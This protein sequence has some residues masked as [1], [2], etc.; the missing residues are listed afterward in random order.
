MFI[1]YNQKTIE[2]HNDEGELFP[3]PRK[4][5]EESDGK[6]DD[7]D[8][9]NGFPELKLIKLD[10]NYSREDTWNGTEYMRTEPNSAYFRR[11]RSL[12]EETP[13]N[14]TWAN[15]QR[16]FSNP[17]QLVKAPS[18]GNEELRYNH[19]QNIMKSEMMHTN[20]FV[21]EKVKV[22]N[23]YFPWNNVDKILKNM[24]QFG[25]NKRTRRR[26]VLRN[27]FY[28]NPLSL[29][30]S[31]LK[32]REKEVLYPSTGK[33]STAGKRKGIERLKSYIEREGTIIYGQ[34]RKGDLRQA[35]MKLVKMMT[36][37]H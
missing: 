22:M 32:L 29:I 4:S 9:G 25:R 1:C 15:N 7:E 19:E 2:E 17:P 18:N 37:N 30:G 27:V 8:G 21:Y 31:Y 35:Q 13:S 12:F 26:R 28:V 3:S 10:E 11:K 14:N 34:Q 16:A 6:G 33:K 23:H 36:K 5:S 24:K 20:R